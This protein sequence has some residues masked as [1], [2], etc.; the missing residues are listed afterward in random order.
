M[1]ACRFFPDD[2]GFA[3]KSRQGRTLPYAWNPLIPVTNGTIS[4]PTR[5]VLAIVPFVIRRPWSSGLGWPGLSGVVAFPKLSKL[6]NQEDALS[7]PWL[8]ALSQLLWREK[9]GEVW[10]S[11]GENH[12]KASGFDPHPLRNCLRGEFCSPQAAPSRGTGMLRTGGTLQFDVTLPFWITESSCSQALMSPRWWW[13]MH[14]QS[15]PVQ[16]RAG[17]SWQG[18]ADVWILLPQ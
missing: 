5:N 4:L 17:P 1:Q 13:Q 14:G 6:L 3:T 8:T 12:E 10:F 15:A 16:G 2:G 7:A 11:L 9:D 18:G